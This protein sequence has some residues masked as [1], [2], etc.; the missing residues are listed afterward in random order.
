VCAPTDSRLL[1]TAGQIRDGLTLVG[2]PLNDV[3]GGQVANYD[4]AR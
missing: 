2:N 3:T 4:A 1:N